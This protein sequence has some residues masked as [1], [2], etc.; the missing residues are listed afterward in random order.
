MVNLSHTGNKYLIIK[1]LYIMSKYGLTSD[2]VAKQ[3]R[4]GFDLGVDIKCHLKSVELVEKK[5]MNGNIMNAL[6]FVFVS[7]TQD[8]VSTTTRTEF[9]V[10]P[11]NTPAFKGKTQEESVDI[12]IANLNTT[13]LHVATKL[14]CT[15]EDFSKLDTTDFMSYAKSYCKMI[16]AKLA[17]DSPL[18]YA[19]TV[20][21]N[22]G[23]VKLAKF[24][25]FL[26]RVD[27]GACELKWNSYEISGNA[28][29]SGNGVTAEVLD[30]I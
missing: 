4:N 7:E 5:S 24:V 2:K 18:L 12:A 22:K 23:Y 14:K 10:V 30:T 26:Q 9:E 28:V 27:S 1:N 21:D 6:D 29:H 25:P 13:L 8:T 3:M 11:E 17:E 20:R 16:N 19:K 15:E